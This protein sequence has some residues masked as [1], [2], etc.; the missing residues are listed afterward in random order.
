MT[1]TPQQAQATGSGHPI[2]RALSAWPEV[3]LTD[4]NTPQDGRLQIRLAG[5]W[6]D[7][8]SDARNWTQA[9]AQVIC[10]QM[11]LRTGRFERW[12]KATGFESRASGIGSP[13]GPSSLRLDRP[14]CGGPERLVFDCNGWPSRQV[15]SGS[16]DQLPVLGLHCDDQLADGNAFWSGIRFSNAPHEMQLSDE[17]ID[18]KSTVH[19]S[20]S[21]MTHVAIEMAGEG[22]DG[23]VTS[24]VTVI[25]V[26]PRMR[27]VSIKWSA[28]SGLNVTDA[29]DAIRLSNVQTI[30]NRGYGIFVNSSLGAVKLQHVQSQRNGADGVR[31]VIHDQLSPGHDFCQFAKSGV[32]QVYPV[33][34]THERIEAG[35]SYLTTCCQTFELPK[36][37]DDARLTLH[38]THLESES[39][40]RDQ[41]E[42]S[43]ERDAYIEVLDGYER[44]RLARFPVRS[45]ARPGSWTSSRQLMQLCYTPAEQKRVR[46]TIM[47]MAGR[48]RVYD[49]NVTQSQVSDNNGRGIWL[50]YPRSGLAL[51][52]SIVANNSGFAGVHVQRGAGHVVVNNSAIRDHSA[53]DGLHVFAA[54]GERHVHRTLVTGNRG[55]GIVFEFDE[56]SV[57]SW[58]PTSDW[59]PNQ[60]FDYSVA[61]SDLNLNG[62][63]G[64]WV[65]PACSS[66]FK[67]NVSMNSIS[68]HA[69]FAF[70]F[71]SCIDWNSSANHELLFTHNRVFENDRPAFTLQPALHLSNLLIAHN[72]FAFNR[73]GAIYIDNEAAARQQPLIGQA[74]VRAHVYSNVFA[75]NQGAFV[76]A[77]G[78]VE[79]SSK[80]SA[81]IE[82]NIF[83]DNSVRELNSALNAR[84]R[85]AAV[86]AI[87]SSNVAVLRN[88]LVNP[89][90]RYEL[91]SHLQQHARVITASSNFFG[92]VSTRRQT[93]GVL[94]RVF[95]R[96]NRYDLALIRCIPYRTDEHEWDSEETLWP[97]TN[98]RD[99]RLPFV[100]VAGGRN[101]GGEIRGQMQLPSGVY[102]V[103][104][105]ILVA[106][107]SVLTLRER[108]VLE[109]DHAI[110]LMVQGELDLRGSLSQPIVFRS[111]GRSGSAQTI[112][113]SDTNKE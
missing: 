91:G 12:F 109:F 99:Q 78:L 5:R 41:H 102:R 104:D 2:V 13:E 45:D 31:T 84:A 83:R 82:H 112:E 81:L 105:D 50:Q 101:I 32:T 16:C 14:N 59:S 75:H 92:A 111:S 51:N 39:V 94:R 70:W 58:Q 60:S 77:I 21:S 65:G 22:P 86:V 48:G 35:R 52:H 68:Q 64:L 61:K 6:H 93:S 90:S 54:H 74:T 24:G 47:A 10:R 17:A 110:G 19:V 98:Q 63:N 87:G 29:L 28:G 20:K 53:G 26:P 15:G 18:D 33:R 103:T 95:D 108:T 80:Q 96:K 79:H 46:F 11:G 37:L 8:C 89:D 73:R 55:H 34:L 49:L 42:K 40:A 44:K 97:E 3:R 4:G 27:H 7:V 69:R 72:E 71:E 57:E 30:E 85:V 107:G 106:P 113:S 66:S 9:D 100:R 88:N 56:N 36:S 62:R 25:G 23:R 67:L 76:A 43:L 38:L 1:L